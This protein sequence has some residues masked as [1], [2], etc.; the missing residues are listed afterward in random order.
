[1]GGSA[2]R[3]RLA[4]L[5]QLTL[6]GTPSIYYGDELAMEGA[7][8]PDCRRAYPPAGAPLPGGAVATRA[9]VKAAIRARRTH[10]AL[11]R[12]E[13]RIAAG[14]PRWIVIERTAEGRRAVVA[15]NAGDE[16][17]AVELHDAATGLAAIDLPGVAGD[18]EGSSVRLAPLGA[19]VLVDD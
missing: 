6:P 2:A 9:F 18:L 13:A 12:G 5:L 8:D 17:V 7:A 10:V 4:T 19:A 15:V 16:A 11:R 1:M 3:L 14:G